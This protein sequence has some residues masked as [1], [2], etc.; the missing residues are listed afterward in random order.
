M[1]NTALWKLHSRNKHMSHQLSCLDL[2]QRRM[3]YILGTV[4]DLRREISGCAFANRCAQVSEDCRV[5]PPAWEH[6]DTHQFAR[7]V[8]YHKRLQQSDVISID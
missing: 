1:Y 4:P 8:L 7:C 3:P 2:N 5:N 6:V